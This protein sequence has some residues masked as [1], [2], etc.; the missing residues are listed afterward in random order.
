MR[1]VSSIKG[2]ARDRLAAAAGRR[3]APDQQTAA[4]VRS[5]RQRVDQLEKDVQ[6][7]RRLNQ[8]L[9]D[10]VDVVTEVLVPAA[11]RDD[12]RMRTALARLEAQ[13]GS[14]PRLSDEVGQQQ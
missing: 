2:R 9:S 5:L 12:E 13:L 1:S 11:D 4:R 10:V 7:C 14:G 8:R 6:E 3:A